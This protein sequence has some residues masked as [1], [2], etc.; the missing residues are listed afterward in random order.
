MFCDHIGE[1]PLPADAEQGATGLERW[2]D[3]LGKIDANRAAEALASESVRALL[4]GI[5]G[6][7]PFLAGVAQQEPDYCFALLAD[8]P[9]AAWPDALSPLDPPPASE[10][11]AK[12]SLRRARRRAA[13]AV[14]IADVT[15]HWSLEQV[16]QAL[17]DTADACIETALAFVLTEAGNRRRVALP[18]PDHPTRDCGIFALGMGKLGAHELNYS[19][20]IDLI[21]LYDPD[22][23]PTSRPDRLGQDMARLTQQ[24]VALLQ[25]RT[26][27]GFAFR[28]DLRLRPDPASTPPAITVRAAEIY[29]ESTG[30][31]W[32]RAAMIKARVVAGDRV[33]GEAFLEFLT[34]FV[35]RRSLDFWAI[36]DI[37]SIKRQINAHRGGSAIAVAGHDIKVGRGGIREIEFF[38]QTQQLIWGGR[39]PALRVKP[40][41]K[42]LD[43]LVGAGQVTPDAAREL[44]A[45]YTYLRRLEHRL[46]MVADQQTQKLPDAA[47]L[48]AIARFMGEAETAAFVAQVRATLETVEGHYALLFEDE[49]DLAVEGLGNLVFTGSDPDP[50]TLE[51]LAG[52]GFRNVERVD[53][54]VR[55]WHHGRMAATRSNRSRQLLTE[56]M[57]TLLQTIGNTAD[58]DEAFGNFDRFLHG[59][60]AGVQLFSLFQTHPD[61]LSL[62]AEICGSAP[63][64][65]QHMQRRPAVLDAVLTPEFF[66]ALP[67]SA[68]Q[69]KALEALLAEARDMQDTL[70]LARRY[71]SDLTFQVGVHLLRR[72]TAPDGAATV[73]SALADHTVTAMLSAVH[74]AFAERH[75]YLPGDGMLVLA[76]GKWG[77]GQLNPSSDLDAIVL[78][79]APSVLEQSDGVK[80]LAAATYGAR[81]T[82]RL[83]T[84]L[85]AETESGRLFEVDLRLR[86]DGDKGPLS[87]SLEGFETY[88]RNDAWTWEHLALVRARAVCGSA[89]LRG[90][91]E[92]VRRE[93]LARP[94]ETADLAGQVDHM[95][96]R[97]AATFKGQSPWDVKHRRGGLVDTGFLAQF[98]VLAHAAAVPDLLDPR[99]TAGI[100]AAA[101]RAG[102]VPPDCAE[103]LADAE[104]FWLG[105]QTLMRL[106][107]ADGAPE[108]LE[109]PAVQAVIAQGLGLPDLAR[110]EADANHHAEAVMRLYRSLIGGE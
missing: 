108:R 53:T 24:W 13:L 37:H 22:K 72:E 1:M 33:E 92:A 93:V 14:A 65:G 27:D 75:G 70:D 56:L 52:L 66:A 47:G 3:A 5:F 59:L 35:W 102:I 17:S 96:N 43:A 71:A 2:L 50:G 79:D 6:C 41:C 4:T 80:P 99:D 9:D 100:A 11:E 45:C 83:V 60:P 94:R 25:D 36:R 58:P 62:V 85:T 46:Q 95:R 49:P 44:Q 12:R 82:Q 55:G 21:V 32:E 104:A 109:R 48:D 88:L 26:A 54:A 15:G 97:M 34:P 68:A 90:R 64:L 77:S 91:F 78:Y 67:D 101:A 84:A 76:Y 74:T 106:T 18:D 28:T 8:G 19:S 61:L 51:T 105:L 40:T 20:D 7:S 29:Y 81:L 30:Q 86:P 107:G 110:V 103:A 31:N 23:V 73:L 39:Q 69:G 87:P 57:P 98:L 89:A 10:A 63:L 16:T 38:A 42:A